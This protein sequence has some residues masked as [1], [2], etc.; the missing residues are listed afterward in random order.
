MTEVWFLNRKELALR[1]SF[2]ALRFLTLLRRFRILSYNNPA[3]L[4]NKIMVENNS[5]AVR[6]PLDLVRLSIDERVVVRCRGSRTLRGKLHAYD[7]HMNMVLGDA[8]ET[9]EEV[10][11]D[12][13]TFDTR[14][15]EKTRSFE[16]LFVRGDTIVLVSP[17]VRS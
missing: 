3:Y 6:K 12:P 5:T 4:N 1:V 10:V 17:P 14:V 11:T 13:E 8:E 16:M 9:A 15:V 7:Q 2:L